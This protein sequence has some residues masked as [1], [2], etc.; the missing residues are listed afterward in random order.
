MPKKQKAKLK[1]L[2]EVI[3]ALRT[4]I[5]ARRRSHI[6]YRLSQADALIRALPAELVTEQSKQLSLLRKRVKE[7]KKTVPQ[8]A[9]TGKSKTSSRSTGK[10][11]PAKSAQRPK[12]QATPVRELGDRFINRAALGYA[13]TDKE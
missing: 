1:L 3:E 12:P 2:G 4:A 9:K 13:P 10:K 7:S 6:R 5:N 11:P 8:G